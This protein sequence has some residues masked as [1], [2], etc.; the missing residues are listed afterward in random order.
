MLSL[1][2]VQSHR[3]V[4]GNARSDYCLK[5]SWYLYLLNFL[6]SIEQRM[7]AIQDKKKDLISGAFRQTAGEMRERRI[8]D[9]LS[10]FGL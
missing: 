2:L 6:F 7:L 5:Y 1:E 4:I 10:I 9:I 8:Q 3:K